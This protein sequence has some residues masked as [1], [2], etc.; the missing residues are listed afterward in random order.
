MAVL[1]GCGAQS[2][3]VPL[4]PFTPS[5]ALNLVKSIKPGCQKP[6]HVLIHYASP[7]VHGKGSESWWCVEP[8]QAYRAVS[9]DLHCQIRTHLKIDFARHTAMCKPS[10]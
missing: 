10:V 9:R 6:G 4:K 2:R 3:V 8:A 5:E 7:T 1:A